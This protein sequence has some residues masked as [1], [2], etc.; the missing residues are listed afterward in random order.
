MGGCMGAEL[1]ISVVPVVI[2]GTGLVGCPT[3]NVGAAYDAGGAACC[4]G[5]WPCPTFSIGNGIV[6]IGVGTG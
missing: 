5:A 2:G 3:L 1:N 4:I 6:G